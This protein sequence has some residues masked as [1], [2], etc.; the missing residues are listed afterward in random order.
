M[1]TFENHFS[2]GV[3]GDLVDPESKIFQ[4]WV[5]PMHQIRLK[6]A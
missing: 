6:K 5:H 3:E 2:E 1:S 4:R